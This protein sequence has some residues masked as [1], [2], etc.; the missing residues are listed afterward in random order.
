MFTESTRSASLYWSR[1]HAASGSRL[2]LHLEP[3]VLVPDVV[4]GAEVVPQLPHGVLFEDG[5]GQ[6][7]FSSSALTSVV[8]TSATASTSIV[9]SSSV[10]CS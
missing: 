3:N 7:F 10:Q 5:Q 6:K 1:V 2:A 4:V 9:P 8:Y